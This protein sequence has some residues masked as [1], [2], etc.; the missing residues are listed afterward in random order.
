M[1]KHAIIKLK[2]RGDSNRSVANSL[3]I[4]RKTVANYWN[5]Y[6]E[7][8]NALT[9][10]GVDTKKIQSEMV[11][12]P[13][14]NSSNRAS[15]KY[16]IAMDERLT[17]ILED[18]KKKNNLLGQHKQKL[19]QV[20]I[21]KILIDEGFDIGRSTIGNKI[22]IKL[23]LHKECFIKQSYAYGDR[24]EYDF[25]E[26]KLIING[27][28]SKYH[29]AVLSSPGGEFRW[30]FL[31]TNQKKESFMDSHV[32][33]FEMVGGVYKEVV[34]DNMRNVVKKFIGKTEK[35]LNED[36][37]KMS[38]YYGFDINVTNC[39]KGNEKGY[40]EG[41]VK[42][43]RNYV[44]ALNYKFRTFDDAIE[45]LNSKLIK[46]NET[47]KIE[48][49][50][51]YLLPYKPK[52][53]LANISINKV[54][55]Y[56][57]VTVENNFY[58]VPEYLVAKQVTVKSYYDRII[59]F[60]N[61]NRVCQHKK[62]DGSNEFSITITHYLN[63]LIRKPGAIKNSLALK[64]IPL[65]KAIYDN[66]FNSNRKKFIEILIDNKDKTINDI[67][68][69]FKQYTNISENSLPIDTICS[70]N[71]LYTNTKKQLLQYAV[72]CVRQEDSHA[73]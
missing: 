70:T 2:L 27:V 53:E 46:L 24:L 14:Y 4:D 33:F 64:S 10:N 55:K 36:L 21:H 69:V 22:R 73:N 56:S 31:Y 32:K 28:L 8:Q 40:V 45:Y 15:R 19:S 50:K 68:E 16:T 57:F 48:E 23:D 1:D 7:K 59:V 49:E 38:M 39:F 12:A 65:L 43:I 63:T 42:V 5:P 18:E 52:L 29:M 67:L 47:S 17:V 26:V 3:G 34:Y 44:F 20:Q 61:N 13:K 6:L 30:A 58:S 71:N 35:Q 62:I 72:L 66:H 51:Q 37:I 11:S 60:A 54:N 25:G 9:L 41:S